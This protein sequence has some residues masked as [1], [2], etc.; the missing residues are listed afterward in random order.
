MQT[1]TMVGGGILLFNG[2]KRRNGMV[3]ERMFRDKSR[4]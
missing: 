2:L 4:G 1:R 3:W